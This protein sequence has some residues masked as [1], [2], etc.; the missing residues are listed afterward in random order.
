MALEY[1]WSP[2]QGAVSLTFDDGTQNQLDKAVPAL[3]EFG[4]QGPL[5][6][7]DIPTSKRLPRG[8]F[9]SLVIPDALARRVGGN[10][11]RLST[12]EFG[13]PSTIPYNVGGR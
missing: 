12:V 13:M 3:D 1:F 4:L 7:N 6:L 9:L 2:Y 10:A 8:H 5:C 11:C